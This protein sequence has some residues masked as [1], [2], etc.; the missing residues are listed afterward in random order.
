MSTEWLVNV[1][2]VALVF[3][4]PVCSW[5]RVLSTSNLIIILDGLQELEF[6]NTNC[7]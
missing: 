2:Q 5:V 3:I 6:G 1:C 7:T 4:S